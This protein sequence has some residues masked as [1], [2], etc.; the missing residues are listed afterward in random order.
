[1]TY[2][3]PVSVVA[4]ELALEVITTNDVVFNIYNASVIARF[5]GAISRENLLELEVKA[6]A[7]DPG[8]GSSPYQF[9]LP[10]GV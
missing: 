8:D 3:G 4:M 1:M 2:D 5:D 7:L 10:D 6:T 9:R